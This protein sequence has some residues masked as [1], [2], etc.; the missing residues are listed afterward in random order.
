[1]ECYLVIR[2]G[3]RDKHPII[4]VVRRDGYLD[5]E[6]LRSVVQLAYDAGKDIEDNGVFEFIAAQ[7][8]AVL[9]A[10]IWFTEAAGVF[11]FSVASWEA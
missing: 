2:D 10:D 5:E 8:R 6:V 7:V 4:G 9:G 11:D 3:Q 1:M